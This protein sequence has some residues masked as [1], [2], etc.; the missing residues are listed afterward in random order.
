MRCRVMLRVTDSRQN[1]SLAH[2]L[3]PFPASFLY[4]LFLALFIFVNVPDAP[5]VFPERL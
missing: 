2:I 4:L 1:I 3:T 5:Y